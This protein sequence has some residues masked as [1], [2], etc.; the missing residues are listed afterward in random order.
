[1]TINW[2]WHLK[3]QIIVGDDFGAEIYPL[4]VQ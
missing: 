2:D 4:S 1:M 3:P